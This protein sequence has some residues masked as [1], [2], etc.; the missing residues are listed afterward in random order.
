M[1]VLQLHCSEFSF[2]TLKETPVAEHPAYP[3]EGDYENIMVCFTCFEKKVANNF[4]AK[5]GCTKFV[6]VRINKSYSRCRT[7][8]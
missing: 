8:Y 1:R 7:F 4:E 5:I 6:R 3:K 2:K